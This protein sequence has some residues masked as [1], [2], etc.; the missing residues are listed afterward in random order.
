MVT[1]D[2]ALRAEAGSRSVRELVLA[3]AG[4]GKTYRLSSRLIALLREGVPP[5]EILAS[6]FTRKAAG[7]IVDRVLVR[8]ARAALD[9]EEGNHLSLSL[10]LESA[11]GDAAREDWAGLLD[12]VARSLDRLQVHTLDAFF[13]RVARSFAQ[14]LGLPPRWEVATDPD[15]ER[16]RSRA[17][18]SALR[19]L[20]PEGLLELVRLASRGGADRNVH[21]LL[22]EG[23]AALH[24][25]YLELDPAVADPWGFEGGAEALGTDADVKLE[26]C[27]EIVAAIEIPV[28]RAGTPDKGWTAARDGGVARLLAGELE[29]F[30]ARGFGAALL[31]GRS[32][33]LRKPLPPALVALREPLLRC[34]RVRL[35]TQL[36]R[37]IAALGRF[38]PEYDRRLARILREEA[39]YHFDDL[40]HALIRDGGL[41]RRDELFY[42]L[43]ARIR[44]VL[45]DEFQDTSNAQW[46]ALEPLVGE[47]LA[48]PGEGRA[49]FIVGDPKQSIFGWRGGEPRLLDAIAAR[50][51]LEPVSIAENHRSSQVVL[52]T[53]NRVF[54]G[55]AANPVLEQDS[56]AAARWA[57]AFTPHGARK[58]LAGY[59]RFETGPEVS[60]GRG[61]RAKPPFSIGRPRSPR[62]FTAGLR[63]P[64]S[65][66]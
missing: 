24:Q 62:R 55:V 18:E 9:A 54:E 4:S 44:H 47:I 27:A 7:E 14:E 65:A 43:D 30:L 56:Q 28:T 66:C 41:A 6:T 8:L 63:G 49:V 33:Y 57:E 36:H 2:G 45:L 37:R 58:T 5:Q 61:K 29:A 19:E 48:A 17:I 20:D 53:V 34:A 32:E 26:R 25:V 40:A 3:S 16:L 39:V 12:R 10:G 42:R 11:R 64:P 13:H 46:V 15:R 51:G 38:L 31:E 21:A 50:Y 23:V 59:V 1:G 22:S 60:A 35:G 52:D